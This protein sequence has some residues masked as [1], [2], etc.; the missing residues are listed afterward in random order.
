MYRFFFLRGWEFK[1]FVI[2]DFQHYIYCFICIY[3]QILCHFL[4][5][6]KMKYFG[7]C[8]ITVFK[9]TFLWNKRIRN[10]KKM[11]KRHLKI[12]KWKNQSTK[13]I[14]TKHKWLTWYLIVNVKSRNRNEHVKN[15][16]NI[17][18]FILLYFFIYFYRSFLSLT[19]CNVSYLERK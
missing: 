11:I 18:F 10:D 7:D 2:P 17:F 8:R 6:K 9:I 12:W 15:S 16:K 5:K 4:L 1:V 19:R 13:N 3:K 14:M